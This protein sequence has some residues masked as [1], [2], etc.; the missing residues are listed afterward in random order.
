MRAQTLAMHGDALAAGDDDRAALRRLGADVGREMAALDAAARDRARESLGVVAVTLASSART[1]AGELRE[2]MVLL[3]GVAGGYAVVVADCPYTTGSDPAAPESI[4]VRVGSA[5]A[6]LDPDAARLEVAG[7]SGLGATAGA[8]AIFTI[9]AMADRLREIVTARARGAL[10]DAPPREHHP[11][12]LPVALALVPAPLFPAQVGR[13]LDVDEAYAPAV[14]ECLDQME[15]AGMC[16]S[17]PTSVRALVR[18]PLSDGVVAL[19][20]AGRDKVR[21]YLASGTF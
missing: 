20:R 11:L 7:A 19:T 9:G 15:A 17:D 5:L 14:L 8:I 12:T 13:L 1:R 10:G 2:A 18:Q 21:A 16:T 4:G 6:R 3:A